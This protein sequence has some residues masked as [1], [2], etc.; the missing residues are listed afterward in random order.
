MRLLRCAG[1]GLQLLWEGGNPLVKSDSRQKCVFV[2]VDSLTFLLSLSN[3]HILALG[4]KG[5]PCRLSLVLGANRWGGGEWAGE[6]AGK[7]N[8]LTHGAQPRQLSYWASLSHSFCY[9]HP[10]FYPNSVLV[11]LCIFLSFSISLFLPHPLILSLLFP[12]SFCF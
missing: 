6:P 3:D 1:G 5:H 12:V 7:A 2:W 8:K 9:L 10:F 4:R 11:S